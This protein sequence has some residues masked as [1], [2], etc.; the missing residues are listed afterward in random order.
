MLPLVFGRGTQVSGDAR[1]KSAH[2]TNNEDRKSGKKVE[3]RTGGGGGG[4][5]GE[6]FGFNGGF[7]GGG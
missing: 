6:A 3:T 4:G 5:C 2:P 1:E 7:G